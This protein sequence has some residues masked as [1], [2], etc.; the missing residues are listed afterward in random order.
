M[1]A[2]LLQ[3]GISVSTAAPYT[4][5]RDGSEPQAI[6]LALGSVDR[7]ALAPALREVRRVIEA[8]SV[9]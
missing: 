7:A 9:L 6:R 2:E 1:A 8:H 5:K 3:G 4:G